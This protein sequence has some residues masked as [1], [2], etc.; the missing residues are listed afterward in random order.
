M[1]SAPAYFAIACWASGGMI[2]SSVPTR[3]QDGIVRQA[4]SPDG[5]LSAP[6]VAARW[7][8]A[9]SALPSSSSPVA[10]DSKTVSGF[11]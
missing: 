1:T 11:R 4:G 10:N 5:S 3:Y 2:R 9:T 6:S 8:A 7:V